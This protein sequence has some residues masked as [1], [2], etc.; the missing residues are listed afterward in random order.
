MYAEGTTVDDITSQAATE[1]L[2]HSTGAQTGNNYHRAEGQN[3]GNFLTERNSSRVLAPPGGASQICFGDY[4]EPAK[5]KVKIALI[6]QRCSFLKSSSRG[7]D[8]FLSFSTELEIVCCAHDLQTLPVFLSVDDCAPANLVFTLS[9]HC[10][11]ALDHTFFCRW[12]RQRSAQAQK[13]LE[14]LLLETTT[15]GPLARMWATS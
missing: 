6:V 10:C 12:L 14:T 9:A 15:T 3:V 2:G 8:V 11:S 5:A 1:N 4:V 7:W 13:T